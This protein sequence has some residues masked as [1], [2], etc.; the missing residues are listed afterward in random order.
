M[1]IAESMQLSMQIE[2]RAFARKP[3]MRSQ[4]SRAADCCCRFG[5][6]LEHLV[7]ASGVHVPFSS[8]DLRQQQCLAAART[9]SGDMED[10][11]IR[12][13]RGLGMW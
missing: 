1:N 2:V 11:Q 8:I 6:R 3:G 10:L 4:Q 5:V 9:L 12:M 13:H 7:R